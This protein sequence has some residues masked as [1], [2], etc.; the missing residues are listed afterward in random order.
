M[1][2]QLADRYLVGLEGLL[3]TYGA[4]DAQCPS[5][6][7]VLLKIRRRLLTFKES[8]ET[9]MRVVTPSH[10]LDISLFRR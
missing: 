5:Y 9:G 7:R 3:K 10:N 8:S 1:V 6:Q 2:N 4:L